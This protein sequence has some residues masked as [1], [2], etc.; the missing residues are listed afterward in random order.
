LAM[1]AHQLTA[2]WAFWGLAENFGG[3]NYLAYVQSPTSVVRTRVP[4]GL[5]TTIANFVDLGDIAGIGVS[6]SQ[7]R[8]YFHYE[9]TN[10]FGGTN[11]TLG[12]ATAVISVSANQKID[13]LVWA[14]VSPVQ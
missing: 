2:S 14:P 10:Q 9:G 13:H 5:T 7:S 6:L 8:W 12:S 1:P 3:A 11:Q 4:D